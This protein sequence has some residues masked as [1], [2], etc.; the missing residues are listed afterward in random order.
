MDLLAY[1]GAITKESM[2]MNDYNTCRSLYVRLVRAKSPIDCTEK[3]G[4]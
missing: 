4:L 3:K 1:A 2:I